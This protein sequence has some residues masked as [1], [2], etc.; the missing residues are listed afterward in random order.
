[1]KNSILIIGTVV[2]SILNMNATNEKTNL[3]TATEIYANTANNIAQI[4]DWEV[5]TNKGTYSGTALSFENAKRMISYSSS[6][7]VVKNKKITSYF[8][9]E[10]DLNN[11]TNRNYFWEVKTTSGTAKGYSS[12]EAYAQKMIALVASGD[13][14]VEKLIMSQPQQ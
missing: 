12:S 11:A 8:M 1:M 13:V 9:L 7:E 3:N 10:A 4:F 5:K 14:I 6:G 2:L